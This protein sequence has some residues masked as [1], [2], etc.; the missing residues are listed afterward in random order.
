MYLVGRKKRDR[1]RRRHFLWCLD[2]SHARRGKHQNNFW[3]QLGPKNRLD[4][5][6]TSNQ[7]HPK[8]SDESC[9]L[10]D[11]KHSRKKSDNSSAQPT[12]HRTWIST[13]YKSC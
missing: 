3:W 9:P 4:H 8:W 1:R 13:T 2:E 5:T 6:L 7:T 12:V 11:P 10:D